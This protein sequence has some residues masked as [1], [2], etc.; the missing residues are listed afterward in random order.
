[1]EAKSRKELQEEYKR[2]KTYMG[3]IKVTN[4]INGKIYITSYPN[5]KNRW[6]TLQSQLNMGMHANFQ[7]Q[8]DWKELG[9]EAFSYEVLEEKDTVDI[10]DVRWEMKQLE[11][12]WLE[13]LQPFEDRGY[14]KPPK[15]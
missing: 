8:R 9:A 15:D 3:V 4:N 12:L 6:V 5:L 14:N 11:R 10:T 7:L 13:K 1:M 2:L